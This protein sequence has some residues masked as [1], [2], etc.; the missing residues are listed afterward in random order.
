MTIAERFNLQRGN[1]NRLKYIKSKDVE[2]IDVLIL[3]RQKQKEQF[4]N[5]IKKK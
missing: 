2:P 5:E 4:N 3:Q 1:T